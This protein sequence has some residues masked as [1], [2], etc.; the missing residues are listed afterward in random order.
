MARRHIQKCT[1]GIK[2]VLV[3]VESGRLCKCLNRVPFYIDY[4]V[5]EME[6]KRRTEVKGDDDDAPDDDEDDGHVCARQRGGHRMKTRP[7]LLMASR[8]FFVLCVVGMIS[9]IAAAA[10]VPLI[11]RHSRTSACV[12]IVCKSYRRNVSLAEN[13]SSLLSQRISFNARR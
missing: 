2:R 5:T 12:E 11:Q 8:G 4:T 3:G 9:S 1:S 13:L 7:H 10:A 6:H